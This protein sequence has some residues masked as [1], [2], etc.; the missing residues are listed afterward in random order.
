[1]HQPIYLIN[2]RSLSFYCGM[3]FLIIGASVVSDFRLIITPIDIAMI[4]DRVRLIATRAEVIWSEIEI[5]YSLLS[6]AHIPEQKT[7]EGYS[8]NV[9]IIT[10]TR[11]L[12]ADDM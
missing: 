7:H 11:R 2:N 5:D 4:V 1:M 8:L 9:E 10:V 12:A 6:A 3:L